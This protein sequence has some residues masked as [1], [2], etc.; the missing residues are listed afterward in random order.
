MRWTEMQLWPAN[1][2]ALAASSRRRVV[3]VG[4]RLDDHRRRVPEL[5]LDALARRPL[6]QLP[7]DLARAG[8]GDRAHAL[9]LDEHVAELRRGPDEHVE[10]ARRQ[11]GLGLELRE[12]Q[13]GEGRLRGGLQHDGAAGRERGRDLVRDEVEREV[14]RRDRADDADRPP[15][16]E[17]ELPGARLRGVHRHHLAG[18]L[19]RLDR[20][21]RVRRHRA[22]RLDPRRLERLAGLGRDRLRDLLVAAAEVAGDADEDLG[23]L[24]RRQRLAHGRLGGVD[25]P[26]CLGAP[27]FATRPTSSPEYGE[28]T[29]TQSPV[30]THS[31]PIRSFFSDAVVAIL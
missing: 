2:N 3:E 30:S 13:R 22:R 27:A 29:S 18:Q 10:P 15:E 28:R 8:E 25:R 26:P 17:R 20:G 24:V 1:E 21:H 16:R 11:A 14:E 23:A 4:V 9:V 6:G 5:E 31:P 12:Q 7:A 19:A